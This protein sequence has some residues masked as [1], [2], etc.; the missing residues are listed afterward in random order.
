VGHYNNA[1]KNFN[2]MEKD[3]IKITGEEQD[4]KTLPLSKPEN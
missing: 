4:L 1:Y 2:M 3:I